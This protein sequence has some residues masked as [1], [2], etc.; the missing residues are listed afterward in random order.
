M[1]LTQKEK[2]Q[3][4]SAIEVYLWKALGFQKERSEE[5][6]KQLNEKSSELLGFNVEDPEEC[7]ENEHETMEGLITLTNKLEND[8]INGGK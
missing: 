1:E 6:V 7:G 8:L 2:L 4:M 3:A 5:L